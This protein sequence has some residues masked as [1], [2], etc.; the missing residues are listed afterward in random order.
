MSTAPSPLPPST[1]CYRPIH[2]AVTVQLEAPAHLRALSLHC[3]VSPPPRLLAH[4]AAG[5]YVQRV[6]LLQRVSETE[7]ELCPVHGRVFELDGV[8]FEVDGLE[9]GG[10]LQGV[11]DV[12]VV[13][14]LVVGA[15][16]IGKLGE[17]VEA[18][19]LGDGVAGDVEHLEVDEGVEAL[20][21]GDAVVGEVE[22]L[23]G[24]EAV[25]TLDLLDAVALDAQDAEVAE[26]GQALEAGD[27][28]LAEP[29]LAE[30]DEGVEVLDGLDAVAAELQ[31]LEERHSVEVLDL[32]DLVLDKVEVFEPGEVFDVLDVL[33]VVEAEVEDLEVGK[34]VH[35]AG[36]V[37]DAVV[38]EVE[39]LDP[40]LAL[41]VDV[42]QRVEPHNEVVPEV[43][44]LELR[45]ALES[46][47]FERADLE[48]D[49]VDVGG[50][51]R[52]VCRE[53]LV[54]GQHVDVRVRDRREPVRLLD[55]RHLVCLLLLLLPLHALLLVEL[56]VD[57]VRV[58]LRL[59]LV[60]RV[61]ARE[62]QPFEVLV[63]R[64]KPRW[65]RWGRRRVCAA[66]HCV[67]L[68]CCV[69]LCH[70][71]APSWS[72]L[73]CPLLAHEERNHPVF[74]TSLTAAWPAGGQRR[75]APADRC[76]GRSTG[77]LSIRVRIIVKE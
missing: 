32:G 34:L 60:L 35:V 64:F 25:E 51:E 13:G 68:L 74:C 6:D 57:A 42:F 63:H 46:E 54:R 53:L 22:L 21:L 2:A 7:P 71:Q 24:G 58:A 47:V 66:G 12:G 29:Q 49:E 52:D 37:F 18:L 23:E 30:A 45:E 33:D 75:V 72:A 36:D 16:E 31:V 27:P 9:A 67:C 8:A 48:V 61:R 77:F 5:A 10:V 4:H 17:G 26:P 19:E 43:D 55:V 15:P 20:E 65:P 11:V 70:R 40:Q 3:G 14:D 50:V 28:V 69:C 56:L 41:R 38:V 39:L 59:V 62:V 76:P 73:P 1:A 44:A